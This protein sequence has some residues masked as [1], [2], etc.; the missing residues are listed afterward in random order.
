M[1]KLIKKGQGWR[2]GW[3][4]DAPIYKGLVGTDDW[5]IELTIAEMQDFARLIIQ[6]NQAVVD[7]S[8]HLMEEETIVCE[9][10]SNLLWLEARGYAHQYSLTLILAQPR[11]CEVTFPSQVLPELINTIKSINFENQTI[12]W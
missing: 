4:E 9:L 5:A 2:I 7:I 6:I 8:E 11:C 3:N 12:Q 10:E 1:G